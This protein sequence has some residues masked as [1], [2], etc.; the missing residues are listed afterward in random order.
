L[1]GVVD[2]A[3]AAASQF[4]QDF[5]AGHRQRLAACRSRQGGACVGQ[6]PGRACPWLLG[7]GRR[8]RGHSLQAP[9]HPFF[10]FGGLGRML[11]PAPRL[12]V[13]GPG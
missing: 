9:H 5:V 10:G 2:D 1:P 13:G 11:D 8:P 12:R 3:H 7:R 6:A 4:P